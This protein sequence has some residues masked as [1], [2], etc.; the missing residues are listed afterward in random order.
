[1][2]LQI[3]KKST[4]LLSA[5]T[6]LFFS[7]CNSDEVKDVNSENT[8]T[9]TVNDAPRNRTDNSVSE[10]QSTDETVNDNKNTSLE[11]SKRDAVVELNPAHGEPGHDCAIA[12]GAPLNSSPGI[13]SPDNNQSQNNQSVKLN[14]AHGEPGHDCA[15]AVGQPLN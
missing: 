11:D 10:S 6:M 3:L 5:G 8:E 15:I 9:E 14:P 1:M 12:V 13:V 7:S 2:L 4:F